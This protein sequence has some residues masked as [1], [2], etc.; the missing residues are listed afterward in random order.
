[1]TAA[2]RHLDYPPVWLAGFA[3]LAWAIAWALPFPGPGPVLRAAGGALVGAA[4][5]LMALAVV[6]FL[7]QRTTIVPH[8]D[9]SALVRG[10]IYRLSRNPI[11]LGDAAVLAGLA[12]W[13][14]SVPALLLVPLFLRVI[15]RRFVEAEEARLRAAFGA[16]A[17]AFMAR[18]RRWL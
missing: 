3:V 9:P 4:G 11:Y 6:E 2:L 12:L 7:R 16:D 10:G 15:R 17:E 8:R 1:M 14:G 13:W 18:V 5:L